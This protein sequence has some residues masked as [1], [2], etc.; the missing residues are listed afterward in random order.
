MPLP[1]L[2]WGAGVAI[3]AAGV[4]VYKVYSSDDSDASDSSKANK[5]EVNEKQRQ[6]LYK[7]QRE[8]EVNQ[9]ELKKEKAKMFVKEN[10][11]ADILSK[12]N[13][14]IANTADKNSL[15]TVL[16]NI[17]KFNKTEKLIQ[18]IRQKADL[19]QKEREVIQTILEL[20]SIRGD[21]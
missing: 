7:N 8:K 16:N 17:V 11:S 1:L 3:V 14:E 12:L 13:N 15:K 5:N 18:L 10:F 2:A 21:K 6:D 20:M 19:K 4:A 9:F